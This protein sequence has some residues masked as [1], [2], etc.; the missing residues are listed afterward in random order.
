MAGCPFCLMLP[1]QPML[2]KSFCDLIRHKKSFQIEQEFQH[3]GCVFLDFGRIKKVNF[4][5][6]FGYFVSFCRFCT[7]LTGFISSSAEA[8]EI[9]S[10][11]QVYSVWRG[12]KSG[13]HKFGGAHLAELFRTHTYPHSHTHTLSL[14]FSLSRTHAHT[15]PPTQTHARTLTQS[16]HEAGCER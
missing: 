4:I 12:L 3:G 14:S 11:G 5:F 1:I 16:S 6:T 9:M 13:E 7:F 2:P 15:L 8:F 10:P